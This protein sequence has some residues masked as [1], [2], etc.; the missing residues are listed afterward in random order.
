MRSISFAFVLFVCGSSQGHEGTLACSQRPPFSTA[1]ISGRRNAVPRPCNSAHTRP[2][3]SCLASLDAP[4]NSHNVDSTTH[5]V[6]ASHIKRHYTWSRLLKSDGRN[7]G[8]NTGNPDGI[9]CSELPNSAAD[10]IV[11]RRVPYLDSK[12]SPSS[13]ISHRD[14]NRDRDREWVSSW[15]QFVDYSVKCQSTSDFSTLAR[16]KCNEH[17]FHFHFLLKE[18]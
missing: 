8:N 3:Y 2:S 16:H 11:C 5:H 14:I 6:F 10:Q 12:R 9:D 7:V 18:L 15:I 1:L 4:A 17:G 13:T